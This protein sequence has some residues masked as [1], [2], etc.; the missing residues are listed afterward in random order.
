MN[1]SSENEIRK[2]RQEFKMV[3]KNGDGRVDRNE[4]NNFLRNRGVDDD[5]RAQILEELFSKCD[6]DSNGRIEI[7]EFVSFYVDTKN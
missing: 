6:E 1:P 4:M 2:L 5:H 7:D 3:D